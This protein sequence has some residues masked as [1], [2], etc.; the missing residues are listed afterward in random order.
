MSVINKMLR[1]LDK[2]QST[3]ANGQVGK[4][5]GGLTS[6][7][8]ALG[9]PGVATITSLSMGHMGWRGVMGVAVVALLLGALL[10]R[11]WVMPADS[12]KV[13]NPS[14]SQVISPVVI[15][16][17][18]EPIQA[19]LPA[20]SVRTSK[21]VPATATT[22]ATAP[23]QPMRAAMPPV[24]RPASASV[25][26]AMQTV[27]VPAPVTGPPVV[28]SPKPARQAAM[29]ALAQAQALWNDGMHSGAFDVLTAAIARLETWPSGDSATLAALTRE[30]VRMALAMGQTSG[31]LAL[32][33]RLEPQLSGVAD[34]WALRG[35]VTQRLGRHQE[36]TN[37]YLKALAQRPD[38]A[39]WMLGASVSLAALGQTGPAGELAE[40]ARAAG[41]LKPDVATY[42]R[43]L[44][45]VIRSD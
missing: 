27:P 39:R 35:N 16:N 7:T 4:L 42:L 11:W 18:A 37:A 38:E 14:T 34:V 2:R 21:E 29:E 43:Q 30:Y 13:L 25:S 5:A 15:K 23:S 10:Y 32:L 36:A 33:E 17:L 26:A 19:Q 1:D 12:I 45:V 31:A 8:A 3:P 24:A 41:V 20:P 22:P 40:K 9:A 44:G 6:G 28:A